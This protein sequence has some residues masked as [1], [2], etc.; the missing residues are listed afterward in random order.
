MLINIF[1]GYQT[2]FLFT[3]DIFVRKLKIKYVGNEKEQG[4]IQTSGINLM[5]KTLYVGGAR[6]SYSIWEVGGTYNSLSLSL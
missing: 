2:G 5:D 1:F 6:I 4:D 3:T